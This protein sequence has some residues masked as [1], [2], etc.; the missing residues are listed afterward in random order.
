MIFVTTNLNKEIIT[1]CLH[2]LHSVCVCLVCEILRVNLYM[3]QRK[4]FKVYK[5]D[6]QI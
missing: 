2:G 3:I 1:L 4:V 6:D 5:L